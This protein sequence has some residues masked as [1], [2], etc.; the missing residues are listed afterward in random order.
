MLLDEEK[1]TIKS[2][3][4][5]LDKYK[6]ESWQEGADIWYEVYLPLKELLEKDQQRFTF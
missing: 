6:E 3:L 4:I 1:Q 2:A 5:A